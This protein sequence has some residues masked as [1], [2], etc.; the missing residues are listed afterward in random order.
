MRVKFN[1]HAHD[2]LKNSEYVI[3][4][5]P[6]SINKNTILE[7]GMGKGTMLSKLATKYPNKNFI[8]VEVN[9]T[10]ANHA[11]V[12]FTK[13]KLNNVKIIVKD[14]K[15]LLDIFVGVVD[16]IYITFPDPWHKNRHEKRRLTSQNFINI[17]KKLLSKNG[18]IKFK[19]DND[20]LYEYTLKTFFRNSMKVLFATTDLHNSEKN[21]DN[22]QTD[23]EKKWSNKNK[24]INYIEATF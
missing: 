21:I 16:E 1:P 3:H 15:N 23:Y 6:V 13:L 22:E 17:Y 11:R 14:V 7:L 9:E 10:I 2:L 19:T 20:K 8:G 24:N 5:F 4:N 18:V 12:L